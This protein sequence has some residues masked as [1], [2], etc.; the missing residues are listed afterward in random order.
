MPRYVALLK[1]VNVGGNNRV[2]MADW[3]ALLSKLGCKDIATLLNSGNAVFTSS[4]RSANTLGEKIR[5]SIATTLGVDVPVVVKSSVDMSAI[6]AGNALS[7]LATDASSL[8]VA[9]AQDRKI[10][11]D[12]TAIKPL[13]V[14]KEQLHI[15]ADAAY[16]WCA[17]NIRD[18]KAAAALLGK[19]GRNITT[20]NWA[21]VMKIVALAS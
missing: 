9:F 3:K 14:G 1:G 15:G 4:E 2:P 20:R 11:A 5:R 7:T 21:T 18:S 6:I 10:L 12:L 17:D 13:L 16:L 19:A 8:L